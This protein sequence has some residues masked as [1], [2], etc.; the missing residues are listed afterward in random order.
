LRLS[1]LA[2]L[3]KSY[4]LPKRLEKIDDPVECLRSTR[5]CTL[6]RHAD[7]P[8]AES[9]G[10]PQTQH[11]PRLSHL[12]IHPIA[13]IANRLRWPSR[14]AAEMLDIWSPLHC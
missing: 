11:S 6:P 3:S 2:R 7:D 10:S 8:P 13:L 4:K 9:R 12:Q 5:R 14:I 1:N